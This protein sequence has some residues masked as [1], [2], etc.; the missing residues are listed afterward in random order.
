[1]QEFPFDLGVYSLVA[2]I[3][4][5]N[6]T[7]IVSTAKS[8]YSHWKGLPSLVNNIEKAVSQTV[9]IA[10]PEEQDY[11]EEGETTSEK[12]KRFLEFWKKKD[13]SP[14][15]D[16]NE[17][18][19]EYFRRIGY[20]DENFSNYIEGWRSDRGMVYT[21][22]GAPNNVDRHPFE[23]NT[24]PYEVWE[25]YDLNRSF[26]FQDQTGFGDYRLIT[27]LTGDLYRYRY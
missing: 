4:D 23:Y 3:V 26:I 13:P 6:G 9:Y 22:L 2:S 19:D 27:P 1:L 10:S 25:Y 16:E 15:N 21:I 20:A 24:K 12:T 14:N 11:M 8:F 5:S 17:I 7:S 18:F